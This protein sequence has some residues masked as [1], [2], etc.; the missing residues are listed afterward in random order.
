MICREDE[1]IIKLTLILNEFSNRA[2]H[3][4]FI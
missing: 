2:F 4:I 3:F 1:I